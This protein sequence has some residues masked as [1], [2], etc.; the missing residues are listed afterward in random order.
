MAEWAHS[1]LYSLN[2]SLHSLLPP[3][4]AAE[5]DREEED[6]GGEAGGD[7]EEQVLYK[8]RPWS[9][10]L[11]VLDVDLGSL[12]ADLFLDEVDVGVVNID[13]HNGGDLE[14]EDDED[15]DAVEAQKALALLLRP[16]EPEEGDEEGDSPHG[17]ESIVEV[18]VAGGL[19]HR[20]LQPVHP[21][22]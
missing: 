4:S 14:E 13:E 7:P 12:V 5:G 17:E 22:L 21:L 2:I 9:Q 8:L 1:S 19:L 20:L 11:R 6:D 16:A 15:A 3:R 10:L 18:L